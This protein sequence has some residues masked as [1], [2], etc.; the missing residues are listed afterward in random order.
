LPVLIAVLVGAAVAFLAPHL[1]LWMRPALQP[2]FALTMLAVGT[3]V[4]PEQVRVFAIGERGLA[5]SGRKVHVV[6][7]N[8][9]PIVE[10]AVPSRSGCASLFFARKP[11]WS[12]QAASARH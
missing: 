11:T 12:H 4:R 8:Q 10:V 2:A 1:V 6:A 5:K 9:H 7:T 3:L